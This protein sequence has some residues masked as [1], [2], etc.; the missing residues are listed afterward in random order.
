MMTQDHALAWLQGSR[1]AAAMD[2]AAQMKWLAARMAPEEFRCLKAR[3]R[4]MRRDAER[5]D[6]RALAS[7]QP[8]VGL[9]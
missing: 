8:S 1:R 7:R 6:T 9:R 2:E 3:L 4:N 5:S